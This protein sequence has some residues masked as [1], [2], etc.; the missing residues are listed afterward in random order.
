MNK[1][2][3]HTAPP[4]AVAPKPTQVEPST[5]KPT[6][7]TNGMAI[8]S[9]VL[10]IFAFLFGWIFLG[11]I[12]GIAAII[13][14]IIALKRPNGKGMSIAGIITGSLGALSALLFTLIGGLAI[15]SGG[16]FLSQFGTE[17]ETAIQEEREQSTSQ[18]EF[19]AGETARFGDFDV[20][21]ANVER[22]FIPDNEF[23]QADEGNELIA[24]KIDATNITDSAEYI[25][26]FEFTLVANGLGRTASFIS[27]SPAFESGTLQADATVSGYIVYEIPA[28][29]TDL[30]LQYE[31]Y[32]F[33]G[34]SVTYSLEV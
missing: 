11:L 21:I 8:T 32:T 27:K 30:T 31:G 10:G 29:A 2:P 7:D 20:Q 5:P 19:A 14:G 17:L 16:L 6:G 12:L 15:L 33:L 13:F 26:S 18:T 9:L 25:G 24:L 23:L 28:G 4:S 34:D 1:E 3:T 22:D